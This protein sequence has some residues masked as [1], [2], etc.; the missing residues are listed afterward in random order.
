MR[1]NSVR[2]YGG[3][4]LTA[5]LVGVFTLLVPF[6][7]VGYWL[8]D[9]FLMREK[10]VDNRIKI[11]GID[12][13]SLQE[14]GPFAEWTRQDAADLLNAFEEGYEPA[15]VAF[16][17]NY[18]GERDEAGDEA[19]VR[20]AERMPNVVAASYLNF[21]TKMQRGE[22]GDW[23][24]NTMYVDQIERPY[25]ALNQVVH[26]GFTNVVQD[27]DNY[28]RRSMLSMDDENGELEYSFAYE[29]YRVY[30]MSQG[31]SPTVPK[32]NSQGI[33]GF[34][35]TAEPGMYEVYSYVDVVNG[36]YDPKLFADSI[37]MVGAYAAAMM[38]QY[39]APIA[40]GTVVNGVE[41]Q[42]NH[43][44]ALLSERTY[45]EMPGYCNAL[46]T[47]LTAAVYLV[48]ISCL[49]TVASAVS[50]VLILVAAAGGAWVLY[51]NGIYWRFWNLLLAVA[52]FILLRIFAGYMKEVVNKRRILGVFRQYIAPQV[53]EELAKDK[54]FQNE[55][56]GITKDVAV[57]FVDIRGFTS[58]SE[59]LQPE[60]VVDVLN[61]YLEAVTAAI[62]KNE[63][64]L[65]KF[66]GDAVMAVYNAPL[67]V[68]NYVA[69][70]VQTGRDIIQSVRQLNDGL[71][72]K[73]GIEIKCGVGVHCGKAVIGNIGCT[74]RMDYTAIGD[75][76]NTAERLES[77]APGGC[78]YLS[79]QVYEQ[80]SDIYT[81]TPVGEL[82]L[83]GKADK[84]M[85]YQMEVED[86][87][88]SHG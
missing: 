5:I 74:Y 86:E 68:D 80:L 51:G 69:K 46:L 11:I 17:I 66:I 59:K 84:I 50:G 2:L 73:Y 78:V 47:G 48:L 3:I 37:V 21:S 40:R 33:Y 42:A 15:V 18:F 62:F 72:Q 6:Q 61:H 67:S 35:Y 71:H 28:I 9:A 38:D 49:G 29:T 27:Q 81:A 7:S 79:G 36:V 56:G 55:L 45:Q 39:L 65:D 1:K 63:G 8:S 12:E 14:M 20:A 76:V 60:A 41:I 88:E 10:P 25:D 43:V 31:A 26:H 19:F 64:M 32:T 22:H 4:V 23:E 87:S 44:N 57:L 52:V 53:V 85:V 24:V 13:K 34:D 83:K 58:M 77:K 54:D 16:D 70:A 82:D 30:Q 75:T